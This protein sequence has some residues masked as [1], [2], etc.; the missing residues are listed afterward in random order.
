MMEKLKKWLNATIEADGN[1]VLELYPE[2]KQFVEK[3]NLFTDEIKLIEKDTNERFSEA[4]IERSDKETE[5]FLSEETSE[6]LNQPIEYFKKHQNEFMY[7]ESKWFDFINVDAVSFEVDDVFGTYNILLGL[8]LQKKHATLIKAYFEEKMTG[9]NKRV[10]LMFDSNEGIWNVNF[11]LNHVDGFNESMTI[12]EA[13]QLTYRFLF[14]LV[15][16][17][18]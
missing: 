6:F 9:D 4:Y 18:G 17:I 12:A 11:A 16:R 15:E 7:L 13:Y 10:D 5:E 14:H 8:K 1:Q 2:E 3:N